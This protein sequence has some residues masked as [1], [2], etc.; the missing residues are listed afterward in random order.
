MEGQNLITSSLL[1]SYAYYKTT[2]N[3]ITAFYDFVSMLR[4]E[5]R[6][7]PAPAQRGIDFENLI[8]HNCNNMDIPELLEK[9]EQVYNGQ[10]NPYV[11][12]VMADKCRGGEQ[13]A[14][15]FKDIDVNGTTYHLFGYADILFPLKILDIKTCGRYKGEQY[16]RDRVQHHIYSVCTGIDVFEY[17]IADFENTSAPQSYKEV[18]LVLNPEKSMEVISSR[19]EELM[20]FL[21][22]KNLYDDYVNIFSRNH[23]D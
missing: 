7:T 16:Y 19:I 3:K 22:Q 2:K 5:K 14:K 17:V 11:I 15:V 13:Q 12:K 1:D 21:K 23:K 9:A 6:P 10:E 18:S 20:F 8:C 4:R